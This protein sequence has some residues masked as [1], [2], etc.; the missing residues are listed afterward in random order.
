[1]GC[2][3]NHQSAAAP[4]SFGKALAGLALVAVLTLSPPKW[5][6]PDAGLASAEPSAALAVEAPLGVTRGNVLAGASP[7]LAGASPM[8][9][10]KRFGSK[11][12]SLLNR[13][14][15]AANPGGAKSSGR[16]SDGSRASSGLRTRGVGPRSSSPRITGVDR[17]ANHTEGDDVL[18]GVGNHQYLRL[19]GRYSGQS[20]E[21]IEGG[22]MVRRGC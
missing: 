14:A 22:V 3:K 8:R 4:F 17:L 5:L 20:C 7:S 13:A 18:K 1:M 12:R 9:A 15:R 10:M 21:S 19:T 16:S 6:T 2:S 11:Q